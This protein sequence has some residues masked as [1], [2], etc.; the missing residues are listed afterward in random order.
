MPVYKMMPPL[1]KLKKYLDNLVHK[2]EQKT[3]II[4]DPIAIPHSFDSSK[5]QELIGLFA[6]LLAWGQRKT[7]LRKLEELCRIMSYKPY[8]F[9]HNFD[10]NRDSEKL[11][12]FVHRTFQPID[13]AWLTHNLSI[14]L[15]NYGSLENAF[16]NHVNKDDKHIE[17]GIQAFSE[18][19]FEADPHTPTRLKKHLAR[20]STGSA[21]KRFCMYLRWMVR[22]GPVDLGIWTQLDPSQ[23][24]LPIDVHSG[25]QA[26]ELGIL[27]RKQNDWK[28]AQETTANCIKLCP[29]DPCRYDFAFFG[30][31]ANNYPLNSLFT[32][33][34]RVD[35]TAL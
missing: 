31:G 27:S 29:T 4:N 18:M 2:F 35:V 13:A 22:K 15:R 7:I 5:D 6:A 10:F 14:V 17:H 16:A 33:P 25:R 8:S 9:I 23:L 3:F 19:L 12:P 11:A 28:A 20:P 21:C 34:N 26:R 32:G 24:I 1:E 30:A